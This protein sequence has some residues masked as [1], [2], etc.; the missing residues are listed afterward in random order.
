MHTY[1]PL[2]TVTLRLPREAPSK[3]YV[4]NPRLDYRNANEGSI[5]DV[6]FLSDMGWFRLSA[7]VTSQNNR[8]WLSF[9]LHEIMETPLHDQQ[10]CILYAIPRSRIIDT[11]LCQN[12]INSKRY[13]LGTG[14]VPLQQPFIP[15][16]IPLQQ[17]T[18]T[19]HTAH[20]SIVLLRDAHRERLTLRTIWPS[21][22]PALIT[23]SNKSFT[24]QVSVIYRK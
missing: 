11:I 5:L 1:I 16:T 22:L 8:V 19:T 13:I 12:T 23:A 14:F 3:Y 7:H 17:D 21:R 18:A 9:N 2:A 6:T 15:M 10:L 24:F 4:K 20:V